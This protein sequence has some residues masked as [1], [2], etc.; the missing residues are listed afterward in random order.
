[1]LRK[2]TTFEILTMRG[3]RWSIEA[4]APTEE[5]AREEATKMLARPN[6][7]GVRVIKESNKSISA[8]K[9]E[10]FLFEKLRASS[11]DKIFV[12]DIDAAPMC[13]SPEDLMVGPGRLTLNKLFRSYLDK[14]D[15]TATEVMHAPRELKRLMDEGTLLMSAVGK[16]STLQS[17]GTGGAGT[18]ERRDALFDFANQISA[19]GQAAVAKK[20]PRIRDV[21]FEDA[22]ARAREAADEGDEAYMERFIITSD[23]VE[24]RSYVGKLGQTMEWAHNS[25]SDEALG[26][27]DVFVSD[28]LNNADVLRELLGSQRDLGTALVTMICFA[29]GEPIGEEEELPEAVAPD[30]PK[31]AN[32][33]LNRLIAEGKL[34]ESK[35]VIVDRIRRQLEGL[36]PLSRGDREEEREVFVG[37]LEKLIPDGEIIGGP[38]MAQ[39]ITA[40]QSTIINK[41][42]QKGMREATAAMMPSLRDPARKTGYLLS[43]MESEVGQ[44]VLKADIDGL[45]DSML[46]ESETVNHIVRDKLPPNKK[47]EKVTSIFNH[48]KASHLPEDRKKRLTER[49]DELLAAYIVNG[50]ILDK[51][52]NPEKPLHIRAFMLVNM[53]QPEMLPRGKASALARDII[54]QHLR[55]PNFEDEMVAGIPDPDE[56]ESTLRLFHQKLRRSGFFG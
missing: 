18:A 34:P 24:N 2:K 1:M 5:A 19:K 13:N 4:T 42:G 35:A 21:G 52:N 6:T 36:S 10:D 7:Q 23:L 31:F 17:R 16:A 54:L 28:I 44:E 30:H 32:V 22:L 14:K 37:L 9:P 20:L 11:D 41:G 43:L 48:I 3:G 12:H 49:L 26:A 47:M 38:Q 50:K 51:L 40:R 53:V 39:A 56:K 46:L 29:E 27:L 45:L 25:T 33:E 8:L 15:I 55:R